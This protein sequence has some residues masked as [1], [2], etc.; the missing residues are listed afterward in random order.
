VDKK[1]SLLKDGFL[2]NKPVK[3]IIHGFIDTGFESWVKVGTSVAELEPYRYHFGGAWVVTRCDF[4]SDSSRLDTDV[5]YN[6]FF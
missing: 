5:Q 6:F 3:I 2:I 1:G 4:G